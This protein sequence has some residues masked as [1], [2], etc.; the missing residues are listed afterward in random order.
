MGFVVFLLIVA[1]LVIIIVVSNKI[2]R[3]KEKEE[4]RKLNL[5]DLVETNYR[6]KEAAKNGTDPQSVVG[7]RSIEKNEVLKNSESYFVVK[8]ICMELLKQD[9]QIGYAWAYHEKDYDD[10]HISVNR[11]DKNLGVIKFFGYIT[12]YYKKFLSDNYFYD[13]INKKSDY[14]TYG[15]HLIQEFPWITIESNTPCT[16]AP[17][18]W[19]MI[20]AKIMKEHG[21]PITDP[22]WVQEKP[23]ARNYVNVMFR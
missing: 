6:L 3:N 18:E 23:E 7:Y 1:G 11:N 12:D 20:C 2:K 22:P 5:A 10:A 8:K 4:E 17:P 21:V 14:G 19:L 15:K 9:Y 16:E 13:F